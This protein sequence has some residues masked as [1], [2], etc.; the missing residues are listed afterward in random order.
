VFIPFMGAVVWAKS[1]GGNALAEARV[2]LA[3][4]VLGTLGTALCIPLA[5]ATGSDFWKALAF[6]GFF[7]N[8]F[9]LLPVVPLDGGRA[10]AALTPW[11]WFVG[12]FAVLVLAFTFPNPIIL[13]IALFAA[14][15]T[16]HRWRALRRGDDSVRS[17]YRVTRGQRAAIAAVYLGLI[18]LLVVGMD[19]THVARTLDD[20]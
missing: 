16:W 1:L 12:L 8:L 13:L 19:A 3:G 2:G 5:S 20:V 14:F 4:P 18:V 11:M 15:D 10:M 6:T 17:Y 9:N 7:L